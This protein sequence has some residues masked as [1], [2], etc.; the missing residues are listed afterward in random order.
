MAGEGLDGRAGVGV[1]EANVVGLGDGEGLAVG[2]ER[3]D[4]GIGV[5]RDAAESLDGLTSPEFY[6]AI[7]AAG[8]D[9]AGLVEG[10]RVD[11]V[12]MADAVF[13]FII[14]LFLLFKF[15]LAWVIISVI[16]TS[17]GQTL[18]QTPQPLHSSGDI[19]T[20]SSSERNL[21]VCGP[22]YFGPGN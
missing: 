11:E 19:S 13:V 16:A 20:K 5:E 8:E 22:E 6:L 4:G 21:W 1:D 18:V 2:A 3:D 14:F 12:A 10:Q 15:D 9:V 7:A 17:F